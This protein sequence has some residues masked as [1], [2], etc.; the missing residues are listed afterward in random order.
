MLAEL[1]KLLPVLI[2]LAIAITAMNFLRKVAI[3]DR[4]RLMKELETASVRTKFCPP[5]PWEYRLIGDTE[6][7]WCPKC[8]LVPGADTYQARGQ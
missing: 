7:I 2:F 1:A 4:D 8:K 5:H 6:R 3:S